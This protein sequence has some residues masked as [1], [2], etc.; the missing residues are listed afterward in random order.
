MGSSMYQVRGYIVPTREFLLKIQCGHT[1]RTKS[2]MLG[3]YCGN[4]V[5]YCDHPIP[6]FATSACGS[7]WST[8]LGVIC[9][10][11]DSTP[12]VSIT[13]KCTT[14]YWPVR[15][16]DTEP[17]LLS[18]NRC[19]VNLEPVEDLD[20]PAGLDNQYGPPRQHAQHQDALW[21]GCTQSQ[22]RS[23]RGRGYDTH[24]IRLLAGPWQ[25]DSLQGETVPSPWSSMRSR[26]NKWHSTRG[27]NLD[28]SRSGW[29]LVRLWGLL[30]DHRRDEDAEYI[31]C[32]GAID[33][34]E[35]EEEIELWEKR[36]CR[37]PPMS[38]A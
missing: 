19:I 1:S 25:R 37:R 15:P 2:K 26:A 38:I 24:T 9:W 35:T 23:N 28:K 29:T 10:P 5:D 6:N 17:E 34:G 12:P 32:I 31:E 7:F 21:K 3:S 30:R 8:F 36:W 22:W 16:S 14:M 18:L 20:I 27:I 11:S 13:G 4:I 33:E